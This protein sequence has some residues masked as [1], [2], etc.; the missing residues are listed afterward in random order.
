MQIANEVI[1][2]AQ[3][4]NIAATSSEILLITGLLHAHRSN[5]EVALIEVGLGGKFDPSAI[6]PA[7]ITCVTRV[8]DD[9]SQC[10]GQDLD[11]VAHE[12]ITV[13]QKDSWFVS[14][15][16]SKLRL[17][18]MKIWV[19]QEREARWV[20]PIRKLAPLPYVYEQLYGRI[21]SLG[22]R[23][24]Q[25]YVEEVKQKFSPLRGNLLATQQGQ[26][27]RPTLEA[28]RN[29]E[30]NPIKTMKMFW[31]EQFSLLR[32]RFEVLEKEKPVVLLDNASNLD[33]CMNVFLGVRLLH[34]QKLIKGFVL[35]LGVSKALN[36][37]EVVK[38]VRYL[39]KKVQG[40][41]FF[42]P[43][44]D[45]QDCYAPEELLAL[46]NDH[47]VKARSFNSFPA[48]IES[49]KNAVDERDGLIAVTGSSVMVSAYW[50]DRGVKKLS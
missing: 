4:H 10:L 21:A 33:A 11:Q 19:E 18:K 31:S 41:V 12:L 48:A 2:L 8:A 20:M 45:N 44:P 3:Q 43:L 25:I 22:E 17:Q 38:A 47:N 6:C 37:R 16:Q 9:V 40:E 5:A 39:L 13:A 26:R 50:H 32:G 14:A 42:I 24:I 46:A 30:L 15:E 28:K 23:I 49:A 35:I 29:A 1:N 34:Y 36:A 27:G 7:H